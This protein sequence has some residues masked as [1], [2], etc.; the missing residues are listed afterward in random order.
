MARAKPVIFTRLIDGTLLRRRPDGSFAP[1]RSA[2]DRDRIARWT[3]AEIEQMARSDLDHPALDDSFWEGVE[4]LPRKEAISIKLDDDVLAFFRQQGRGYQT[5]INAV[6]R[7][8][9]QSQRKAG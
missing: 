6:L 1:V 8:Y 2:S 3:E 5:R 9:V 4:R 7:R